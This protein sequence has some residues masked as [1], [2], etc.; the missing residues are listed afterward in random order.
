M[1]SAGD[2]PKDEDELAKR[3]R[4]LRLASLVP[5]V[6]AVVALILTQDFSAQMTIFDQW[7]LLF[8]GLAAVQVVDAVLSRDKKV[9]PQ[10]PTTAPATA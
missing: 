9:E 6:G 10:G 3:R 4:M 8:G 1:A 2:E 5:A 7:S